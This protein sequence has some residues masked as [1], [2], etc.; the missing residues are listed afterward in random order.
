MRKAKIVILISIV[1]VGGIVLISLWLNLQEKKATKEAEAPPKISADG[2]N[3]RLEKI[4][5]IEDKHGRKTWELEARLIEQYQD[6]NILQLE[7]VKV[8]FFTEEGRSF[9]LSGKQGKLY[10][11]SKN[12]ELVG[13][14]VLTSSDGYS[15]KTH[16]I[17]YDHK[18]RKA[19]TSDAVEIEGEQIRLVGKGML[20]DVEAKIFKV[21][22]QVK[23]QWRGEK[24]G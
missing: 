8:T 17:T 11:N 14:V 19:R 4:R 5:L 16:S 6:Q 12:F 7:E 22:D 13:D 21:F 15:L 24:K 3:A 18:E 10:Q 9:I 2:A 23:T 20:V 1:L